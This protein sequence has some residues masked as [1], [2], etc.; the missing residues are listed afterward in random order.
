MNKKL[1]YAAAA[2]SRQ[3]M[4]IMRLICALDGGLK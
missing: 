3:R 2:A 1:L 4:L